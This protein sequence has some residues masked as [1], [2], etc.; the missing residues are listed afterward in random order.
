MW[1]VSAG[2]GQPVVFVH[3]AFCDARYW[4]P[5]LDEISS[6][7]RTI[8]VSLT[9]YHPV[10]FDAAHFSAERHVAEVAAFL[11]T[12]D[13]PVHLVGHSRGGRVALHV[14][15]RVPQTIRSLVL[16]EPGGEIEPGFLLPRPQTEVTP[17]SANVRDE[18]ETL[19]RAGEAERGLRLYIDAG[20]GAGSFDGLP[21]VLRDMLISNAVT[22]V[23]MVT[24]RTAPLGAAVAHAVTGP[25]VLMGGDRSPVIFDRTLESLAAHMVK[26][27]R[28]TL[29]GL[30]HFG[31][32]TQPH[33]FN[34]TL[35]QWLKA[36]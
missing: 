4:Q 35:L 15:A 19:V 14:A 1:S 18:V 33:T 36:H 28:V 29:A 27:E 34:R 11:A 25:A 26:T 21:A 30:D 32:F 23:A 6:A 10:P 2:T 22:I 12:F 20:H 17:A 9:G 16:V 5:Q 3:G 8:A 24:D 31:T 7:F 13:A